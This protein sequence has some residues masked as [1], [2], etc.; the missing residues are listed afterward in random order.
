MDDCLKILIGSSM[1]NLASPFAWNIKGANDPDN[2]G[3]GI[4]D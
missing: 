4:V 2:F 1:V 3:S